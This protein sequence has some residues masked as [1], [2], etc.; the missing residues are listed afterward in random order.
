MIDSGLFFPYWYAG[1]ISIDFCYGQNC[2]RC[3]T[4]LILYTK[5]TRSREKKSH[6]LLRGGACL[7]PKTLTIANCTSAGL[8]FQMLAC[9]VWDDDPEPSKR[10]SL[11]LDRCNSVALNS[12]VRT[13]ISHLLKQQQ[14]WV[15]LAY[16]QN[17]SSFIGRIFLMCIEYQ[18]TI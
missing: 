2:C 14:A 13:Y 16:N 12:Q 17:M 1:K 6:K 15:H 4:E 10:I 3:L 9:T 8:F 5:K 7:K 18:E 11:S